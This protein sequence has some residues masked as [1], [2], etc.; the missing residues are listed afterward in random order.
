[1]RRKH[2]NNNN[3]PARGILRRYT[4]SALHVKESQQLRGRENNTGLDG[5]QKG[6]VS[7]KLLPNDWGKKIEQNEK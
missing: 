5:F 7:G 6:L 2:Q 1:M 3:Y 4:V